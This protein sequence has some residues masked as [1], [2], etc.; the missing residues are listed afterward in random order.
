[1]SESKR[2]RKKPC[3]V[4]VVNHKRNVR[5]QRGVPETNYGEIKRIS[6]FSITP[7][8]LNLLKSLSQELN[9]STSELLERFARLGVELKEHL[10]QEALLDK[11]DMETPKPLC[12]P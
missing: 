3:S 12:K 7:T 1:M 11:A 2:S 5:S 10:R 8:A 4:R 6:S 9:I